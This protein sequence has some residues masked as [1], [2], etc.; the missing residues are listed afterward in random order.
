M[1][2]FQ[3]PPD[4]PGSPLEKIQTA[5]ERLLEPVNIRDFLRYRSEADSQLERILAG[6]LEE[7]DR[8]KSQNMM[9]WL[10]EEEK[11]LNRHVHGVGDGSNLF[12]GEPVLAHI[13]DAVA[14]DITIWTREGSSN[15]ILT[16]TGNGNLNPP[17]LEAYNVETFALYGSVDNASGTTS[18]KNPM[19]GIDWTPEAA[20]VD[21]YRLLINGRVAA[22][23]TERWW[24]HENMNSP[25]ESTAEVA[26]RYDDPNTGDAGGCRRPDGRV[27]ITVGSGRIR[28]FDPAHAP[29]LDG[30]PNSF[31]EFFFD[32]TLLGCCWFD[33]VL[34]VANG[35]GLVSRFNG[36]DITAIDA[37]DVSSVITNATG[38][39]VESDNRWWLSSRTEGIFLINPVVA[40]VI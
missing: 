3:D 11:W 5:R 33:G 2:E 30:G 16:V 28:V 37:I 35:A 38:I 18:Q 13:P 32:A 24:M 23:G 7:Y 1:V 39:H 22:G 15:V 36:D 8:R 31:D 17:F 25:T 29:G 21:G 26:F 4:P 19:L 27:Y 14:Q 40:G 12:L 6:V 20:A 9:R 34:Y 10:D